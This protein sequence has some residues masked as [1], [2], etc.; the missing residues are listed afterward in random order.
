MTTKLEKVVMES[1]DVRLTPTS[2][3]LLGLLARWADDRDGSLRWP[4]G[5]AQIRASIGNPSRSALKRA[6]HQL[7]AER[8]IKVVEQGL[9][10]GRTRY[11]VVLPGERLSE[12]GHPGDTDSI[13][14]DE[15]D[16]FPGESS[17]SSGVKMNPPRGQNEPT[18]GSER[19]HPGVKM[20][21]PTRARAAFEVLEVLSPYPTGVGCPTAAARGVT[22]PSCRA[23]GTSPRQR[24]AA[25]RRSRDDLA[26]A[27]LHRE[28]NEAPEGLAEQIRRQLAAA[29]PSPAPAE[30][31]PRAERIVLD[32]AGP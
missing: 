2:R 19:T 18:V 4:R 3:A 16:V 1:L 7:E 14:Q 29:R 15:L 26:R 9:G 23:C 24:T 28:R 27:E 20:N 22:C 6:R 17:P 21:P 10:S 12:R 8:L 5:S 25:A 30:P 11:R 13:H 32:A 31:I